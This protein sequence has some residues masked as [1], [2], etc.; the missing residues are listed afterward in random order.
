MAD[1]RD[2]SQKTEEPT[3][4]R[5]DDAEA[6]G[7]IVKSHEV[8]TFIV[9]GGGT[10]AIAIF[11]QS[12]AEGFVKTFRVFIEQPD[13]ILVDPG[14]IM[15]L[16]RGTLLHVAM[17]F[18]PVIG[19]LVA[20]A[21][22]AHL[23]QHRPVFAPDRLMPDFGKISP[24]AGLRRLFGLD[25]VTNLLKGL[26]KIVIVG[27]IVWMTLWPMRGQ[28]SLVLDESPAEMTAGADRRFRSPNGTCHYSNPFYCTSSLEESDRTGSSQQT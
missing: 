5:L 26:I 4:R 7:D 28:L 12:A 22:A 9:L 6:S 23:L 11:G 1:D 18:G 20:T 14:G 10:L 17:I 21:L 13:Q 19:F 3:Q 8:S 24:Q 15:N 16:M 2:D 27:S 25:G